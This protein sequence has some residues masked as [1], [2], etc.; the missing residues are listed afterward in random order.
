MPALLLPEVI[1]KCAQLAEEPLLE[2]HRALHARWTDGR[3]LSGNLASRL[4]S[5]SILFQ[6]VF[7][8][9]WVDQKVITSGV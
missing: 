6:I 3:K 5:L 1:D 8:S 2:I 7:S 9:L 4:L